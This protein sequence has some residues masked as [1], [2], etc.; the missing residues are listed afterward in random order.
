MGKYSNHVRR[1]FLRRVSSFI[2][3]S[4]NRFA[5][6]AVNQWQIFVKALEREE[7]KSVKAVL[8]DEL[9]QATSSRE[10]HRELVNKLTD[11][12]NGYKKGPEKMR[13]TRNGTPTRTK[14]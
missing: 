5:L 8:E 3:G 13:M 7:Y 14:R 9:D 6:A 12:L 1:M 11:Q 2:G 10:L 4:E